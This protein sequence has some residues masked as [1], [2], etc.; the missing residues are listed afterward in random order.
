MVKSHV[1]AIAYLKTNKDFSLK[2]L[3]KYLRN[4]D[5]ELLE[6]S[7]DIYSQDFI[8]TPYPIMQGLQP[9]YDYV[10][11]SKPE[12]KGHKPEEFMD[13]SFIAEL[14]KSGFIKRLY[15]SNKK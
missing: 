8:S 9:T 13:P 14:D 7:Y 15:E 2:V 6:G 3:A 12:I 10:A 5:K 4:N 11:L 1:E